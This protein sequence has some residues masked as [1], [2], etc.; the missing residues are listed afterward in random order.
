MRARLRLF[1]FAVTL[2][3]VLCFVGAP[4]LRNA[5]AQ[6][7]S[8]NSLRPDRRRA[9]AARPTTAGTSTRPGAHLP[10]RNRAEA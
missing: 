10:R 6:S 9:L 1:A 8:E 2:W 5:G 7:P 4:P 3:A